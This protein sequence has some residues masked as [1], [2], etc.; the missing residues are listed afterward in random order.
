MSLWRTDDDWHQLDVGPS[1]AEI[2]AARAREERETEYAAALATVR[3]GDGHCPL[4]A[5]AARL[6]HRA[7]FWTPYPE[8]DPVAVQEEHAIDAWSRA[9]LAQAQ[10][11][12]REAQVA[13]L[14]QTCRP[15]EWVVQTYI[16]DGSL[17]L[18]Y[19]TERKELQRWLKASGC[20]RPDPEPV[21]LTPEPV[22]YNPF[23]VLAALKE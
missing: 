1:D 8:P 10:Q 20:S 2:A 5:R 9:V 17:P 12:E 16:R 21:T 19:R 7:C 15:E 23:A 4:L 22:T 13:L 18:R 11:E 3:V 6:G 14:D